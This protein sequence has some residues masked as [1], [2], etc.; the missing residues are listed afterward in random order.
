MAS[1]FEC[2]VIANLREIH[3]ELQGI[4]GKL[5]EHDQRFDRVGKHLDDFPRLANHAL[6]LATMNATRMR[7]LEALHDASEAWRRGMD[8]RLDRLEHR[9]SQVEAKVGV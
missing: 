9:L 7:T 2:L 3:A 6:A 8:E 1:E 5:A 4:A